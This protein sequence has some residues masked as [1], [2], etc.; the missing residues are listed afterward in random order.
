MILFLILIT[1]VLA[2][3]RQY[4]LE[5]YVGLL[6]GLPTEVW[7]GITAVLVLV[8]LYL[9]L[10]KL[11]PPIRAF[12]AK[13]ERLS[14]VSNVSS[15]TPAP[16]EIGKPKRFSTSCRTGSPNNIDSINPPKI[17]L[18]KKGVKSPL[19]K[20]NLSTLNFNTD[21]ANAMIAVKGGTPL[22]KVFLRLLTPMGFSVTRARVRATVVVLRKFYSI[23]KGQGHKGLIM[24]LKAN[25]VLLQQSLGGHMIKDCGQLGPRVSR[26]NVGMPRLILSQDRELIRAG[27]TDLMRYYLTLLNL[28]RILDMKGVLK[29]STITS[30]FGGIYKDVSDILALLPSFVAALKLSDILG[31]SQKERNE[32]IERYG[33]FASKMMPSPEKAAINWLNARYEELS[34]VPIKRSAPGTKRAQGLEPAIEI[35]SHPIALIRAAI[36]LR[37]TSIW[38]HF[39][40]FLQKLPYRNP[41]RVAFEQCSGLGEVFK[42]LPSLGKLGVK[43]EA[44]GK[45]R[46][47]AMVDAWTQW[48]LEPIHLMYFK[49]LGTIKQDGTFDQLKP[50]RKASGWKS[51]YSLD[52]SAATD[53]LPLFVQESLLASLTHSNELASAW[54]GLLTDRTYW[55]ANTEFSVFQGFKYAVGQPMGA[56]SSWASLALTHHFIVQASAWRCGVVPV[57]AWYKDYAILG[58]DLVI[59]DRKVAEEYLRVLSILGVQ[60]GLHKSVLSNGNVVIEFAKRTFYKG[61]DVSPLPLTE[62]V[63]AISSLGAMR[64]YVQKYKLSLVTL[65]KTFGFGYRVLGGLNKPF[66]KLNSKVK[67]LILALNVPL[68]AEEATEFFAIGRP[69]FGLSPGDAKAVAMEF[70]TIES[71]AMAKILVQRWSSVMNDVR[72]FWNFGDQF[73]ALLGQTHLNV[74]VDKYV[75]E[76]VSTEY[77]QKP[78]NVIRTESIH[79]GVRPTIV[80]EPPIYGPA[81]LK[82]VGLGWLIVSG[83]TVLVPYR[84][85]SL[86]SVEKSID[87]NLLPWREINKALAT[88]VDMVILP[89]RRKVL[90]ELEPTIAAIQ[91]GAKVPVDLAFETVYIWFLGLSRDAAK[92]AISSLSLTRDSSTARGVD[93]VSIRLWKRWSALIQGSKF[94]KV[95]PLHPENRELP[96]H[97]GAKDTFIGGITIKSSDEDL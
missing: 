10:S 82:E 67:S 87:P 8:K 70:M 75:E 94:T 89:S 20:L 45:V 41:I 44:A 16:K 35:S 55:L 93:P 2:I 17:G 84:D 38:K 48:S 76:T 95:L 9:A 36:T 47:F 24:F 97:L 21:A 72:C 50:L 25:A 5:Y 73:K 96:P 18:Q 22:V 49:I 86:Y 54:A 90:D 66:G 15:L 40:V 69:S 88:L 34:A 52:L 29:L 79:P 60:C 63:S 43:K 71:R 92:V 6:I 77:P 80:K 19:K 59:G 61:V 74:L 68:T 1:T 3:V 58:D 83:D 28:Y 37:Y 65:L 57:G 32:M 27:N 12:I 42:P 31:P 81:E 53:R 30:P 56:L 39:S 7:V 13:V 62:Y 11:I 64:E 51:A 4:G 23:Y 26:T 78:G 14:N 91:A 46:V 85:K 33:L